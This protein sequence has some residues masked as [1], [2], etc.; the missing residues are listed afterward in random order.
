MKRFAALMAIS[1]TLAACQ[2]L[3]TGSGHSG[4]LSLSTKG[5]AEGLALDTNS[6]ILS[7]RSIGGETVYYGRYGDRPQRLEV[8]P[9]VYEISVGSVIF[10]EPAFDRP[11]FGDSRTVEVGAGCNVAVSFNCTRRNAGVIM[12]FSDSF[13]AG[14]GDASF[15]LVHEA[16]SIIYD[17]KEERTAY[18]PPGEV[19]FVLKGESGEVMLMKRT[20]RAG[21]MLSI[22]ID[23]DQPEGPLEDSSFSI[24]LD[25][26]AVWVS[27][28][29]RIGPDGRISDGLTRDNAL[30]ASSAALHISEKVWVH[31]FIVGG[32]ISKSS[33]SFAAPFVSDTHFG[34]AD[35]RYETERERC[36]AV[37]LP[38]KIRKAL[39][40]RD[41]PDL[42][43]HEVWVYGTVSASY[44]SLTGVKSTSDYA[45]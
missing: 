10:D 18:F 5:A 45:L 28:S 13:L 27:E 8:T 25:T 14:Y 24:S 31:G 6:F 20:L 44:F 12:H 35:S 11:L 36:V 34:I 29:I 40:L 42:L 37:E 15:D 26:S 16:G 1:I 9:D 30:E 17:T 2:G 22:T 3:D 21:Q 19:S 7:I 23:S 41:N 4:L 33:M 38:S 39:N 43:G 32:D